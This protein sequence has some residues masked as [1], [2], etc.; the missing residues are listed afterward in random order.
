MLQADLCNVFDSSVAYLI[1]TNFC[2]VITG[3]EHETLIRD[4]Y[5]K[6]GLTAQSL[7]AKDGDKKR[8]E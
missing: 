8:Y 3:T 1:F 7:A 6:Q 5:L 2:D 4:L